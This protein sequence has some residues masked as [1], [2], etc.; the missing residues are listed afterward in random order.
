MASD[1]GLCQQRFVKLVSVFVV[2]IYEAGSCNMSIV[3]FRLIEP[4]PAGASHAHASFH[5]LVKKPIRTTVVAVL[6]VA[7]DDA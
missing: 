4:S 2:G 6:L 1:S 3:I 7:D 5:A